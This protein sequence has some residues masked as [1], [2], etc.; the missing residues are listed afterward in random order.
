MKQAINNF[1][2]NQLEITVFYSQQSCTSAFK[3]GWKLSIVI[4]IR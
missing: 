1:F 3:Q 2:K 4:D